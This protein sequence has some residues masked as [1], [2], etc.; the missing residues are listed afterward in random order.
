MK[1]CV[2]GDVLALRIDLYFSS[3][4]ITPGFLIKFMTPG[5]YCCLRLSDSVIGIFFCCYENGTYWFLRTDAYFH[6]LC[7]KHDS[8]CCLIQL[9]SS[10]N[11]L[12]HLRQCLATDDSY[13]KLRINSLVAYFF[14]LLKAD[15]ALMMGCGVLLCPICFFSWWLRLIL[16]W[17]FELMKS[18]SCLSRTPLLLLLFPLDPGVVVAAAL[19]LR[20]WWG[21]PMPKLK[22]GGGGLFCWEPGLLPFCIWDF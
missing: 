11:L 6:H 14:F 8:D 17:C 3:F 10:R 20:L 2:V 12:D 21:A 15:D 13:L 1:W 18:M 7:S 22:E 9:L 4:V 5:I 19:S 16:W